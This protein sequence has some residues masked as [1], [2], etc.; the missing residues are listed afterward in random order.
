MLFG[1]AVVLSLGPLALGAAVTIPDLRAVLQN[2]S[3]EWSPQTE[4]FFPNTSG[5]SDATQRWTVY[6]EPTYKAAVR[7]GTELDVQT[8]VSLATLS[9]IPFLATGGR[10]GYSIS[11]DGLDDGLAIDLANFNA[12]DV[13]G[14]ANTVTIGG[15]AH[16][17]DIFDP[18]YAAGKELQTGSCP[19]VGTVGATLGA[20]VG[21]YQGLHGL[22]IDALLSVRLVTATGQ[23][24]TASAESHPDLFWGLRGA[25]MNFGVVTSATY[26]VADL[27]NGGRAL[28]ADLIYPG[29][30]NGSFYGALEEVAASMPKELSVIALAEYDTNTSSTALIANIV[31]AGPEDEGR[32]AIQPFL[33]LGPVTQNVYTAACNE[34]PGKAGFGF[35]SQLCV[36][37]SPHS[38]Y[39]V[40]VRSVSG[41]ALT[42][43]FNGMDALYASTPAARGSTF[44][45]EVFPNEGPLAVSDDETAYPW[46]DS[47]AFIM[48]Q[49]TWTD[50][51]AADAA[52]QKAQE[53]R[54]SLAATSGYDDLVV[55]VSYA[56]GDETPEQIFGAEKLPRLAAL[57]EEWDPRNVFGFGNAVPTS[58]P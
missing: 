11:F 50:E 45:I 3:V 14:T 36:K 1:L 19:C 54:A 2:S 41:S 21:R 6:A 51:S 56:H 29:A 55:Y 24:V 9:N 5:F 43:T 33:D 25:G 44:Q 48:L 10:H 30:A 27:S 42:D 17:S 18:L 46:R 49:A 20:G 12:V 4:L 39:G 7:P 38:M 53:L 58:Y 23:L 8:A 57:K 26:K 31:Y 15:G 52:N 35:M 40:N 34:L 22:M 32:E 16:F 47:A 37:G 13:D 28:S